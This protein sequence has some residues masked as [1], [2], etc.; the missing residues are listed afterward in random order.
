MPDD[1]PDT[2][3]SHPA[4]AKR[5]R[6]PSDASDRITL[7]F[8]AAPGDVAVSGKHVPA[9]RVLEWIDKAAFACAV[10]WTGSNCTTVY[11]GDVN[12][13][14]PIH[15]GDLVEVHARVVL[16]GRT[17]MH[18]LVS[19][20][21]SDVRQREFTPAMHCLLVLVAVDDENSPRLVPEWTPWSDADKTL[22]ARARAR[23]EPRKHI[24]D[25]MARAE[26]SHLGTTPRTVFRFIAGP[27]DANRGGM[28]HGGAVMRWIDETAYACAASWSSPDAVAVYAGGMSFST[29]IAIGDIVEV[30][31]RIIHTGT[32]SMHVSVLVRSGPTDRPRQLLH[33]TQC[34][35]V[36]VDPDHGKA[37][38]IAPLP[39]VS[40]EDVRLEAHALEL[41]GLRKRLAVIPAGL[42]RYA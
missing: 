22:Q 4:R 28:V 33:T 24:Q 34:I 3:K 37:A 1:A 41:I 29:P 8:L 23:I 14:H 5:A 39:L 36:F 2:P 13:T 10:G 38:P 6:V 18:V 26:Y 7:R 25:V 32:R 17:S 15:P 19:V 9:G 42:V 20:E 16:T 27:A 31:A 21:T 11:V 40:E 30:D 35:G 12:F